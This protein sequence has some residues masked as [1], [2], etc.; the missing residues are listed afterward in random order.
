M[1][2][3]LRSQQPV[4]RNWCPSNMLGAGLRGFAGACRWHV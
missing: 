3:L 4:W 2:A 1:P